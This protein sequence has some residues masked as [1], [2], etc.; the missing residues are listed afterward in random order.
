[1]HV[2]FYSNKSDGDFMTVPLLNI[3]LL[4]DNFAK[5]FEHTKIPSKSKHFPTFVNIAVAF[6]ETFAW[7]HYV[8]QLFH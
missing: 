6:C 2:L 5:G 7:K 4:K 8:V 1:M 3:C